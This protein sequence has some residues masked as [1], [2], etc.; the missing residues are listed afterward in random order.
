MNPV[1][2]GLLSSFILAPC[3]FAATNLSP[4]S[5][6]LSSNS[7]SPLPLVAQ[8]KLSAL[9]WDAESKEYNAKVGEGIAPF[10]FSLTN[11][12]TAEVVISN[13][14]TTCGCTVAQ[15]PSQPWHLAP[16]TNGEIKVSMNLAGKL[17]RVTK[18]VT[19]NTSAGTK[20]LHVNVTIPL[21][22]APV[23]ENTRGDR[24]A[25]MEKAKA[26]RQAIFQGDCISCHVAKGVGKFGKELY[27]A[28]CA[29]CHDTPRRAASVPDL[30]APKTPRDQAYWANWITSGR[31][32]SLMPAFGEKDGGPLSPE[33]ID[34]LVVFLMENFPKGSANANPAPS[35]PP[36]TSVR[37]GG[38]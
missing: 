12:S 38:R 16:G 34:S 7:V 32:G 23:A 33:Q 11:I 28:D 27:A 4:Q 18:D 2:G 29:I 36:V 13:V 24:A 10:V 25:N 15:L 37:D 19:V 6:L 35:K 1:V 14:T 17:G 3:L 5:S 8:P 20:V 22:P 30:R 26:N 21:A 31:A 9:A